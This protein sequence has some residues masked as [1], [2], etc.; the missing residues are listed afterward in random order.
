MKISTSK[1]RQIIREEVSRIRE[2]DD[3]EHEHVMIYDQA[4]K[5]L[6][7]ALSPD[8]MKK[9]LGLTWLFTVDLNDENLKKVKKWRLMRSQVKRL[10]VS[11][12]LGK[13]VKSIKARH[14][15]RLSPYLDEYLKLTNKSIDDIQNDGKASFIDIS[16]D[17]MSNALSASILKRRWPKPKPS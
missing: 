1:L 15:P 3:H 8:E 17:I 6:Q 11:A 2:E 16:E 12:A 5:M 14:I 10:L 13:K 4:Y 7:G 9:F